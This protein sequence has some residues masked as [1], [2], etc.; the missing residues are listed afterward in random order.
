M[1]D[2]DHVEQATTFDAENA[3]PGNRL[4]GIESHYEHYNRLSL[5]NDS[6]FNG[7]WTDEKQQT[8]KNSSA[9]VDAI[10]GQLELTDYQKS[11]SHR[12]FSSLPGNF[13]RGYH[14]H[15]VA[16]T[17]CGI[18]GVRDGRKYHPDHVHPDAKETPIKQLINELGIQRGEYY[19]CWDAVKEEVEG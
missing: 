8:K 2:D 6:R 16:I 18:V 12:I 19:S 1:T 4:D 9:I 13:N 11:E 10:A 15:L 3:P 17:V 7:K 5:A 14:T